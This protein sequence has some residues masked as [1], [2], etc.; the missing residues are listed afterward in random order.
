[1]PPRRGC[2]ARAAAAGQLALCSRP[3]LSLGG[4]CSRTGA[5]VNAV[6]AASSSAPVL[7][8]GSTCR[9]F[10]SAAKNGR[11]RRSAAG[12]IRR[13]QPKQAARIFPRGQCVRQD[14][15]LLFLFIPRRLP[16]RFGEGSRP[17]RT[18]DQLFDEEQETKAWD[19]NKQGPS[20]RLQQRAKG[21]RHQSLSRADHGSREQACETRQPGMSATRPDFLRRRRLCVWLSTGGEWRVVP[22]GSGAKRSSPLP[23]V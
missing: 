14:R 17:R 21:C 16:F 1:M 7:F 23:P 20:K 12:S 19:E 6:A 4:A 10:L 5:T 11:S 2:E 15:L 3:S 13:S 22:L 8:T 9:L 18:H